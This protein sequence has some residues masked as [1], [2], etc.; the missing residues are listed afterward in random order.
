MPL[1][2]ALFMPLLRF[3]AAKISIISEPRKHFGR[4]IFVVRQFKELFH[5]FS[6]LQKFGIIVDVADNLHERWLVKHRPATVT[7]ERES[8]CDV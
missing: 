8:V 6:L 1:G 4:K 5:T 2:A 3:D 7:T